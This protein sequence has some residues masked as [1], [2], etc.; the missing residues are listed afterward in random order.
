MST[1]P[2]APSS[3]PDTKH[4]SPQRDLGGAEASEEVL[5]AQSPSFSDA[6]FEMKGSAIEDASQK[7]LDTMVDIG[8]WWKGVKGETEKELSLATTATAIATSPEGAY[9]SYMQG[10]GLAIA[11][12]DGVSMREGLARVP[13][14]LSQSSRFSR[15]M[16]R[17]GAFVDATT[18]A[19]DVME[20]LHDEGGKPGQKTLRTTAKTVAQVTLAGA[21]ANAV[22]V[23]VGALGLGIAGAPL[24]LGTIAAAGIGY[25]VG[26]ALDWWAGGQ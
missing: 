13:K 12:S 10:A 23:G 25:G 2:L 26:K 4:L 8:G 22:F 20:A 7:V 11:K 6:S 3:Q 19:L 21:A 18:G 9:G 17:V 14:S 24:L 5:F 1:D 16:G 15:N